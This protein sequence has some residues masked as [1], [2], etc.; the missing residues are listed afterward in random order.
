VEEENLSCFEE[1][2]ESTLGGVYEYKITRT[3]NFL[4]LVSQQLSRISTL[5][6]ATQGPDKVF[7]SIVLQ[8]GTMNLAAHSSAGRLFRIAASG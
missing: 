4:E 1:E 7:H 6:L 8:R 5:L 3:R 2:R